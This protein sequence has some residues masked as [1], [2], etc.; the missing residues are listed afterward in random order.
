MPQLQIIYNGKTILSENVHECDFSHDMHGCVSLTA[1][2]EPN[3]HLSAGIPGPT[4][5]ILDGVVE[6]H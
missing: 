6:M 2:H 3:A 5:T 1:K 4:G